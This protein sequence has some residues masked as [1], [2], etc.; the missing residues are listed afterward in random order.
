[1][2][3]G[4]LECSSPSA[5]P[6]SCTATRKRSLPGERNAGGAQG[7]HLVLVCYLAGPILSISPAPALH[8][9]TRD[10]EKSNTIFVYLLVQRGTCRNYKGYTV[11]PHSGALTTNVCED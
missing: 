4:S 7:A 2:A 5:W 11:S 1:M 6:S 3:L 8:L 9:D 10:I